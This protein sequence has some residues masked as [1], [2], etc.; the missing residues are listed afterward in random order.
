[1]NKAFLLRMIAVRMI[2]VV[3]CLL[4]V[5]PLF[6]AEQE[7]PELSTIIYD[8]LKSGQTKIDIPKG[9]YSLELKDAV[10]LTFDGL[11]DIEINGNG[12]DVFCRIPSQVIAVKNCENLTI[13]G[14]SF[15]ADVLP[16]TQGTIVAV[17]PEKTKWVD[18]KI[19]DGYDNENVWPNRIQIFDPKTMRLKKNLFTVWSNKLERLP[20]GNWRLHFPNEDPN[21]KIEIGEFIVLDSQTPGPMRT[22]AIITDESKNCTFENITLYFSNCFSYLEHGCHGNR[23]FRC[24]L[25]KKENDPSKGVARLRSGNADSFHSKFATRGPHVEECEFRDH[26]DDCV[27]ING[28]FYIVISG[29][30][31]K[32]ILFE[33]H[34]HKFRIEPGDPVRF[35]SYAGEIIGDAK[36]VSVSETKDVP[37]ETIIEIAEKYVVFDG[38]KELP[39][40]H[41]LYE[42]TLDKPMKLAGGDNVYATNRIGDGYIVRNNVMGWTRARGVLVKS[43]NGEITG[44]VITGCEL[45]GIIVAPELYWLEAGYAENLLIENNTISDCF[46]HSNRGGDSQPGAISV[47]ATNSRGNI[48]EPGAM[49]NIRLRNNTISGCP[50]PAIFVTSTDGGVVTGNRITAPAEEAKRLHGK[51]YSDQFQLDFKEPIWLIKNANITSDQ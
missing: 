31:N 8:A 43:G 50:Y 30:G 22:H 25:I 13:K 44:N 35:T 29:E 34:G 51:R 12:S 28:I 32:A 1:M 3:A 37:K 20:D 45:G 7:R 14:F 27:A 6:A 41:K 5:S 17:E 19:H 36:V 49:K 15:D 26:G 23:Y 46:F 10:P 42:I 11:K 48:M 33:R 2:A 39:K 18:F 16:F 4:L 38:N 47:V 9:T 40:Y 21:R 24:R